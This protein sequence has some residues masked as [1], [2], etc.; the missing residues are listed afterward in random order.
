MKNNFL[1]PITRIAFAAVIL[2]SISILPACHSATQ[3][4]TVATDSVPA[5][6]VH[7]QPVKIDTS[8]KNGIFTEKYTNG[9]ILKK[10]AYVNG[11]K[12]GQWDSWYNSGKPWSENFYTDDLP[13][14]KSTVW[15]ENGKIEYTGFYIKG[16]QTGDWKY[17]DETGKMVHEKN[18]GK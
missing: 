16:R 1:M 12:E 17:Y 18:Y 8:L 13:D 9:I 7:L 10:G 11:K 2:G 15:Y 5:E 6:P 3:Q 4:K 14:G